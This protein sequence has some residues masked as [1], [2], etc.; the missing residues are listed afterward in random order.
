MYLAVV[1]YNDFGDFF[2]G[3]SEVHMNVPGSDGVPALYTGFT[4]SLGVGTDG[5]ASGVSG[6]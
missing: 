2:D 3:Q 5:T 6:L 1:I 4:R